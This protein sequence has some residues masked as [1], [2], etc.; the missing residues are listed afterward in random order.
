MGF[1]YRIQKSRGDILTRTIFT[2]LIIVILSGCNSISSGD[3]RLKLEYLYKMKS[4][5]A[6]IIDE[7]YKLRK[8][9]NISS[10]EYNIQRNRKVIIETKP[11]DGWTDA[12]KFRERFL[13]VIEQDIHVTDSLSKLDS[14]AMFDSNIAILSIQDRQ[15]MLME[16]LDS[17]ISKV[18]RE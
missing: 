18:D 4:Q 1:L 8:P 14:A 12:E 6:Q 16:G 5:L 3:K 11:L 2:I 13:S 17:L 7:G 9:E 10:Y 15:F